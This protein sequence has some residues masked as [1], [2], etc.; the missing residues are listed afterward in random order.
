MNQLCRDWEDVIILKIVIGIIKLLR[1]ILN[2]MAKAKACK[3][4]NRIY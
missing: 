2:K 4:C 1:I 3:I